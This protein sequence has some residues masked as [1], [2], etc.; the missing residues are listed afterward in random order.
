MATAAA[1]V[2]EAYSSQYPR[3]NIVSRPAGPGRV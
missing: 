1:L 2:P 3:S